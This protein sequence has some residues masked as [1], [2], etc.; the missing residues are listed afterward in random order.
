MPARPQASGGMSPSLTPE[1][2]EKHVA[3]AGGVRGA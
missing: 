2:L 1:A 3:G